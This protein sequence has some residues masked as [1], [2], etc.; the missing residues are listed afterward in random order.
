MSSTHHTY[1]DFDQRNWATFLLITEFIIN[2]KDAAST[3]VSLFFLSHG[4]HAKILKTDEKLHAAGNETRNFIQKA[5]NILTKLNQT[6]DWVQ[7]AM[8]VA[9]QKQ[10]KYAD[11]Y[12]I[13]APRYKI[14]DKIWLTLKNIATAIENKKLE[15]KVAATNIW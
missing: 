13:Q 7:T 3:G 12:K 5:D 1:I 6:N 4:Y 14:K 10:Q 9:Q 15:K 8:A 11:T 2:N